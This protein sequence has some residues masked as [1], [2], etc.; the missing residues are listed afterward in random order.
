MRYLAI[1]TLAGLLACG[2][3]PEPGQPAPTG[4]S[5]TVFQHVFT[6]PSA[7]R[8]RVDLAPGTYRMDQSQ[9]GPTIRVVP[10]RAGVQPPTMRELS[11]E[12]ELVVH[13]AGTYEITAV[14]GRAGQSTTL[15]IRTEPGGGSE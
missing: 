6:L 2:G 14:G 8:V 3:S 10:L 5:R 4:E 15:R 11:A 12:W 7:E 1:A 13:A 9:A